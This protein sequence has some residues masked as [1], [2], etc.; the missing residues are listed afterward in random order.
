[1]FALANDVSTTKSCKGP[2]YLCDLQIDCDCQRKEYSADSTT[3][4]I[5]LKQTFY[6]MNKERIKLLKGE[7]GGMGII[8]I[9]ESEIEASKVT[10]STHQ[11]ITAKVEDERS[12][13]L[14]RA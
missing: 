11:R 7:G 4:T 13:G 3:R 1:M 14:R 5:F 8:V 10:E 2:M 12:I 6:N 9:R